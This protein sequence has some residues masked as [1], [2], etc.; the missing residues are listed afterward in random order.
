MNTKDTEKT[1][2]LDRL[3]EIVPVGATLRTILRHRTAS[4]MSRS[5]SV[6]YV[7]P[8]STVFDL[9]YWIATAGIAKMDRVHGGLKMGGCGMDMGFALVYNLGRALYRAGVP[10]TGH[11]RTGKGDGRRRLRCH[12]N[13]H[14]NGDRVYRRGRKHEDGGYAFGQQWL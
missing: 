10:C 9:D 11:D 3:R 14:A 7:S 5:I 6:I 2:A 8:D 12:S 1:E 13:D 4:G